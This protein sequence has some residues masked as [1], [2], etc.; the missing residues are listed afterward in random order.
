M[1]IIVILVLF[2]HRTV[3]P[4]SPILQREKLSK[5]SKS[6]EFKS[7]FDIGPVPEK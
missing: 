3:L 1:R 5:I 6:E 4:E 2:W 7:R